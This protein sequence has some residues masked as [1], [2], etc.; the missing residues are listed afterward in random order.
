VSGQTQRTIRTGK[1][2]IVKYL[3]HNKY[4]LFCTAELPNSRERAHGWIS[5]STRR[6]RSTTVGRNRS[7]IP[8]PQ[9]EEGHQRTAA[10]TH[11]PVGFASPTCTRAAGS[12]LFHYHGPNLEAD[13]SH[14]FVP[15]VSQQQSASLP[16]NCIHRPWVLG[17]VA[18]PTHRVLGMFGL[19]TS[20]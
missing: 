15:L 11:T 14:T 6:T 7:I 5:C 1:K 8:S 10:R 17:Y 2:K 20:S 4:E 13:K 19:R 12:P 18:P 3:I 9:N 16:L